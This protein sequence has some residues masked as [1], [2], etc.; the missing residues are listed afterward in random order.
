M[1]DEIRTYCK[2]R[3]IKF[4]DHHNYTEHDLTRI[5]NLFDSLPGTRKAILTT[6]KD[7]IRL[8]RLN[9]PFPIL[10][11]PIEVAFHND[12]DRNF[13][14]IIESTVRENISFLNKLHI[15]N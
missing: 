2:V 10:V 8:R 6:E 7:A 5:K 1:I 3:H 11:Q 13:D 4:P 15:W 9:P 12:N 14:Q